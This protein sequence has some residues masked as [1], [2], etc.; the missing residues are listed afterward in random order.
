M[1][2]LDEWVTAVAA[3]LKL[4]AGIE[5]DAVLDTARE[6]A[7]RVARPAAPLTAYLMGCAVGAGAD[8]SAVAEQITRL[9]QNWPTPAP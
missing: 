2:V 4:G 6:V 1:N 3:E 8:P 5:R 7:H 9:A